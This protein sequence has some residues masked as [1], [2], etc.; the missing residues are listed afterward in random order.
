MSKS[1]V[2]KNYTYKLRILKFG[3]TF[4]ELVQ[5]LVFYIPRGALLRRP[6]IWYNIIIIIIVYWYYVVD[7][8]YIPYLLM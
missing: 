5:V 2:L 3:V 7:C 6:K 4:P 8:L 1:T